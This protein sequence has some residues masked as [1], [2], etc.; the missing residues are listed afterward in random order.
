MAL[1]TDDGDRIRRAEVAGPGQDCDA[2]RF[3]HPAGHAA[4]DGRT[5]TAAPP[6]R[7]GSQGLHT[8]R[9]DT[10]GSAAAC[11]PG[12]ALADNRHRPASA[13]RGDPA[14]RRPDRAG[15]PASGQGP[16]PAR[17]ARTGHG[18]AGAA[19]VS[20]AVSSMRSNGLS[21]GRIAGRSLQGYPRR[22]KAPVPDPQGPVADKDEPSLRHR[23]HARL[24]AGATGAHPPPDFRDFFGPTS[25]DILRRDR[26]HRAVEA[27]R[28]PLSPTSNRAPDVTFRSVSR[29]VPRPAFRAPVPGHWAVS[30]AA[31]PRAVV[32]SPEWRAS[33]VVSP[34][35]RRFRPGSGISHRPLQNR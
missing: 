1:R 16:A 24:F 33:G 21:R 17:R 18:A 6:R 19:L 34:M 4:P 31:E 25:S 26:F 12:D 14:R 3:P 13:P 8:G 23:P 11:R 9:D 27:P 22:V 10:P 32:F 15:W 30:P 5:R 7:A 20:G 28:V 35:R 29:H 2:S